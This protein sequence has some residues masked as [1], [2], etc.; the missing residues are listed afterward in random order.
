MSVWYHV[1]T[2]LFG[3]LVIPVA[4]S[5]PVAFAVGS[6]EGQWPQ[7]VAAAVLALVVSLALSAAWGRRRDRPA[8]WLAALLPVAAAPAAF[9]LVWVVGYAATGGLGSTLDVFS[10]VGWPYLILLVG[11]QLMGLPLVV[12]VTLAGVLAGS[13]GGWVLGARREPVP[14]GRRGLAI[15]AGGCAVVLAVSGVQLGQHAAVAALLAGDEAMSDEVDLYEY[16]PFEPG[17]RLVT[18]DRP[19]SLAIGEDF[20][21]L[22]GATAL[23]PV[24]GA[25][26]QAVYQ[27]PAGR[28][29][30]QP[31]FVDR[32]L[33]CSTTSQAYDRLIG[34]EAD[35]I[36]V[37][38][39]SRRQ[40][41]RAAG[42]GVELDLHPIGREAFVFFV[43]AD[44][45]VSGLSL[46]Q[47]RDI[48]SHR[49]T[50]WRE[51]GGPDEPIVAFQRPEG[52]G[53]QT[54]LLAL[55]MGDRAPA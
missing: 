34:G 4:V 8:T 42:A 3:L 23:Y 55:V 35:A 41:D 12:P 29:P 22:D 36:F 52:S 32:Y 50:N 1:K 48:Y 2:V 31:G 25:I 7:L 24:Y 30:D 13:V 54:A 11:V 27:P 28:E 46:D 45:P 47:V 33:P 14:A 15:V 37:A 16:R 51:L 26:G 49:I 19:V 39:P 18:P 44:N 5:V 38:Q 10:T 6:L 53:S 9:L 17:N 43:H 40:L 21:R 20:P